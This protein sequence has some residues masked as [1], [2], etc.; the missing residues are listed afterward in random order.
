MTADD[1]WGISGQQSFGNGK[2]FTPG[3]MT[4]HAPTIKL[5]LVGSGAY[6]T[7][8]KNIAPSVGLTWSPKAT[9]LLGKFLGEN[10]QSVFRGGFSIAYNR[11]GLYDFSRVFAANY[12]MTISATRSMARGNLITNTGTD[13]M[14]VLFREKSR[15]GQPLF[16]ATPA[17]LTQTSYTSYVNLFD[18]STRVPYTMSWSFGLQRELTRDMVLEARYVATRNMQ[19]WDMRNLDELNIV[20]NGFLTEFQNAMA[21]LQANIAAGR[22]PNF[23][24]Y[25]ANTG[26]YPLPITLAYFS[27]VPASQASDPSKYTSS[28]FSSSTYVNTLAKFN[29]NPASYANS[30]WASSAAQVTNALTA[31]LP[32]NEFV[33]N[34][35]VGLGGAWFITNGGF[36]H[37]DALQ[38]ELR[39]RF[40]R[41]LSVQANYVFAKAINS[42]RPSFRT[43]YV[44]VLGSTLPHAFKFNFVYELPIGA[45]KALFAGSHGIVERLIG[46]WEFLGTG[47]WQSGNLLNFGNVQLVGMTPDDLR[48]TVGL[49]FDDVNKLAYYEPED[50]RANTI[51]AYNYSATSPT[52]YSDAFGVP[53]GRY[54]AP[55]HSNGCIQVVAGDCA[56]LTLFVRGP[57]FQ[58]FDL[59]LVKRVRLTETKNFELRGEFLN[60]FNNINFFGTTCAGS[61]ASCGQVKSAYIDNWNTQDPGGRLVQLALRINF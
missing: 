6:N 10:G 3:N 23:K 51:A 49:R 55:A 54:V 48:K 45:G 50:I 35:A 58:R 44:K 52:G 13:V 17:Y 25:G 16:A 21:N 9:G 18:P 14:P 12:G 46:G 1:L 27:A 22:G 30:L 42:S 32:A 38:V 20:E 47:R 28:N 39:R 40:S 15:L 36:N 11:N 5:F 61:G 37:Y 53:T 56:P 34:P 7:H 4:G 29:P 31:G 43:P 41:G 57:R 19:P 8:Y 2:L 26:T 24:Y 60:A 33:V 59:S